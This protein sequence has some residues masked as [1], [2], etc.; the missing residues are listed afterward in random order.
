VKDNG[1]QCDDG[2]YRNLDGCDLYCHTEGHAV[3]AETVTLPVLPP[4]MTPEQAQVLYG[5]ERQIS[6]SHAPAGNTGP[7]AVAAMA[8]GAAA[9]YAWLRRKKR[10]TK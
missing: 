7:G 4:G 8:A 1:E 3:A 5:E 9:G 2:N 6:T 10:K